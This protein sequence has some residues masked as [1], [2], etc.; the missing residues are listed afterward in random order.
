MLFNVDSY[1]I[2]HKIREYVKDMEVLIDAFPDAYKVEF[3]VW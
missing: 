3:S 1:L 2:E